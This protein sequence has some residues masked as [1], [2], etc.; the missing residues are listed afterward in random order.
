MRGSG[1]SE[2]GKPTVYDAWPNPLPFLGSEQERSS[3]RVSLP[4]IRKPH[5]ANTT[6]AELTKA[7]RKL[8][9]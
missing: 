5:K 6:H 2:P 3:V 4:L 9:N 8:R 1:I 7:L